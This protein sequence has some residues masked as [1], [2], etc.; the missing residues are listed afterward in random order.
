MHSPK[1]NA[2]GI[3]SPF[4]KIMKLRPRKV[5]RQHKATQSV[6]GRAEIPNQVHMILKAEDLGMA[7]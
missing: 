5:K 3:I 6:G 1:P 4:E 2:V 7:F